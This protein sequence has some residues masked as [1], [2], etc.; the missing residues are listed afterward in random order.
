MPGKVVLVH[1]LWNRG[2][3]MAAMARRLRASGFNVSVFSYPSRGNDIAGHA[4]ELH[5]FIQQSVQGSFNLVGHSLGGLVILNMLD[6]YKEL[7]VRRTVLMGTPVQGS[8]LVKRLSK[9]PGQKLLF[10]RIRGA[11]VKG[12]LHSPEQCET[13]M[14]CGT[15]SFGLGRV[16]GKHADRNDGS[17]L[18]SETLLDGLQ[19]SIELPV[20]H[21]EML[22]S[23]EVEAQV[24]HFIRH[25]HFKHPQ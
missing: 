11:L 6:R 18:L 12:Y 7:P 16:V 4:D 13:G 24:E 3:S 23:S 1:G 8:S 9:V 14:I 21:S 25:G 2:W 15:R 22:I 20:A 5:D 17:V 19:D 10:G